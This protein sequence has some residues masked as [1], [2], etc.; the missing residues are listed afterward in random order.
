MFRSPANTL[1]R[2]HPSHHCACLHHLVFV[3]DAVLCPTV[4]KDSL[5]TEQTRLLVVVDQDINNRVVV[6]VAAVCFICLVE[7]NP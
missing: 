2:P 7:I 5:K 6:I 4:H 1:R 3:R